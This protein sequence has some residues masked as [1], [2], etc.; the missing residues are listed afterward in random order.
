MKDEEEEE[1]ELTSQELGAYLVA[2]ILFLI[3]LIIIVLMALSRKE[4][5]PAVVRDERLDYIELGREPAEVGEA[6]EEA[7]GTPPPPYRGRCPTCRHAI[8]GDYGCF[9]CSSG[10]SSGYRQYED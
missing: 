7:K 10:G 4:E 1:D 6:S 9:Y 8:Y 5:Q 3:V 2:I